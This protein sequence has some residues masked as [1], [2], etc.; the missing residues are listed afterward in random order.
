VLRS[1]EALR[2]NAIVQ[3]DELDCSGFFTVTDYDSISTSE[4]SEASRQLPGREV[5]EPCDG[6][7][8]RLAFSE[9]QAGETFGSEAI[10]DHWA[11]SKKVRCRDRNVRLSDGRHSRSRPNTERDE[12]AFDPGLL[13][14]LEIVVDLDPAFRELEDV[15]NRWTVMVAIALE[16]S[17]DLMAI[18]QLGNG[19]RFGFA[20]NGRHLNVLNRG[21]ILCPR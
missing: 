12:C 11:E 3:S 17:I 19:L 13:A 9:S 8:Q 2:D 1:G 14:D 7:Q 18:I 4:D 20:K 5:L 10:D 16:G 15:R 21:K 6:Q